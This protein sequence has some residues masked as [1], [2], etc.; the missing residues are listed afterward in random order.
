M[1][2][3]AQPFLIVSKDGSKHWYFYG[4]HHCADGPAIEWADGTKEWWENNL[5]HRTDGPAIEYPDGT[6]S[7]WIN[8]RCIKKER[9]KRESEYA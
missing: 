4:K 2:N 5:R 7:W 9:P 8:H 3:D 6:K 1:V